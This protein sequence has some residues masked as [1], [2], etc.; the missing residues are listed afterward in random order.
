MKKSEKNQVI[1]LTAAQSDPY[2]A[3]PEDFTVVEDGVPFT[4]Q[5]GDNKREYAQLLVEAEKLNSKSPFTGTPAR[6][7]SVNDA[8]KPHTD[9]ADREE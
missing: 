2:L 9:G 5:R 6:A 7:T 3:L 1:E 8:C 4:G